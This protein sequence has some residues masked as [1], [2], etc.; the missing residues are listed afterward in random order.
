MRLLVPLAVAIATATVFATP[1]DDKKA[2]LL[3]D[4]RAAYD[5]AKPVFDKHCSSC[6]VKGAQQATKKKLDHFEMSTYPFGGHHTGTLGPTI[7]KVLAIDGGK[8]TMPYKKPGTVAGDDLEAIAAWANA[9]DAAQ[10]GGAHGASPHH[11]HHHD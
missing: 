11:D 4:E 9:W 2:A 3:A 7:R 1:A 6:H 5:K 8:A 10:A